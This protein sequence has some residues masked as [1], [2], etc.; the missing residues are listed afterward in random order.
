MCAS[1]IS[2]RKKPGKPGLFFAS[3]ARYNHSSELV[4]GF[5]SVGAQ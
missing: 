2:D 3:M 4:G 1:T 5:Q